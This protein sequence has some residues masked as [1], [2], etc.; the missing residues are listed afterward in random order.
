MKKHGQR[1]T[2]ALRNI[3]WSSVIAA[4]GIIAAVAGT[5]LPAQAVTNTP[6]VSSAYHDGYVIENLTG[7]NLTLVSAQQTGGT[8]PDGVHYGLG[9]GT[10]PPHTVGNNQQL[11]FSVDAYAYGGTTDDNTVLTY[12]TQNG[13]EV[14]LFGHVRYVWVMGVRYFSYDAS[15]CLAHGPAV[16]GVEHTTGEGTVTTFTVAR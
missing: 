15:A 16:C 1:T 7:K 4:A 9:Y 10:P 8:S 5:A 12:K 2:H 11:P 3:A 14:T 6:D 13:A